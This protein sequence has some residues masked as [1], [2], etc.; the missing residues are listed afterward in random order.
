MTA[1]GK[2]LTCGHGRNGRLGVNTEETVVTPRVVSFDTVKATRI[3]MAAIALDHS[4]FLS[5]KNQVSLMNFLLLSSQTHKPTQG[6]EVKQ[7]S[8]YLVDLVYYIFEQLGNGRIYFK[9]PVYLEEF[10]QP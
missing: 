4:V 5:E 7:T 9:R 3:K 2:V 1:D 10:L 6:I 8:L